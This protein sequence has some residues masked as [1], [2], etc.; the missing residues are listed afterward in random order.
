MRVCVCTI[1]GLD[2]FVFRYVHTPYS[3]MLIFLVFEKV[4]FFLAVHG[5]IHGY[6]EEDVLEPVLLS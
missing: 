4:T 1:P 2:P 6:E 3:L 5:E